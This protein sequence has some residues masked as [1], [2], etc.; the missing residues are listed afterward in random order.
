[1]QERASMTS[2]LLNAEIHFKE[3]F[4][5]KIYSDNIDVVVGGAFVGFVCHVVAG[6]GA[7]GGG[8]GVGVFIWF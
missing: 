1:M 2:C 8:G 6:V 3:T 7:V 4:Q 5:N